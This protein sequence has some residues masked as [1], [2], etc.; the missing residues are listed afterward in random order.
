MS[1]HRKAY[2][3]RN[4]NRNLTQEIV[5]IIEEIQKDKEASKLVKKLRSTDDRLD[6]F[7]PNT[8]GGEFPP[9]ND[10]KG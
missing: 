10:H 9:E 3:S 6:K 5:N 4:K 8:H 2:W 7:D 1:N